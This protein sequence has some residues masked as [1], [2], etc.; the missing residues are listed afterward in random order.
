MVEERAGVLIDNYY[1]KK[2]VLDEIE[3]GFKLDYKAFCDLLCKNHDSSLF[4]TYVYD[5]EFKSNEVLLDR[6]EMLANFKIRRGEKQKQ[7]FHFV[8]KQVDIQLAVDM[9][10][11]SK[12]NIQNI[13]LV[14]GDS[15]FIP[16]VK[17]VQE[18]GTRVYLWT[19]KKDKNGEL[20]RNCD[21]AN[22]LSEKVLVSYSTGRHSR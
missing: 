6:L 11:L 9:I 17:Y 16:V 15:D 20:A 1:L 21:G 12:S 14:S 18:Q 2:E 22:S 10:T 8:Q 13:I 3:D 19:A 4:R 7:G 5:C